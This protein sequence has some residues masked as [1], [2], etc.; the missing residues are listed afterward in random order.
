VD[1]I[2]NQIYSSVPLFESYISRMIFIVHLYERYGPKPDTPSIYVHHIHIVS[3][4]KRVAWKMLCSNVHP[5]FQLNPNSQKV[6]NSTP[7]CEFCTSTTQVDLA[8]ARLNDLVYHDDYYRLTS[9]WSL[10]VSQSVLVLSDLLE[11][12]KEKLMM[13]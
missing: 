10:C 13:E 2:E 1:A 4:F 5:F 12:I 7:V 8:M 11:R 3:T 9:Y 6:T